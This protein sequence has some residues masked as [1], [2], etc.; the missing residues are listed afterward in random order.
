MEPTENNRNNNF[1]FSA[2]PP[3][4]ARSQLIS[5]NALFISRATT[6]YFFAAHNLHREARVRR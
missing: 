5:L 6:Y 1:A 4:H 3:K 2:A